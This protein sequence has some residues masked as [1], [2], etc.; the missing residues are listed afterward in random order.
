MGRACNT[1]DGEKMSAYKILVK[2][3]QVSSSKEIPKFT[4]VDVI[5]MDLR[6]IV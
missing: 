4:W 6:E 2:R 1:K 5:K 3:A